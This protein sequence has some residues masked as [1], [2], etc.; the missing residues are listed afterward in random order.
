MTT[1]KKSLKDLFD[2]RDK[3]DSIMN[4]ITFTWVKVIAPMAVVIFI[5]IYG[6]IQR[7]EFLKTLESE[8][9]FTCKSSIGDT[10]E[11]EID[12]KDGWVIED[13]YF[14][15]GNNK[16]STIRCKANKESSDE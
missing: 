5:T 16:I 12:K 2:S 1:Q 7:E 15:K 6:Y 14:I 11:I 9:S 13:N 4:D 10:M 3:Y 8:N